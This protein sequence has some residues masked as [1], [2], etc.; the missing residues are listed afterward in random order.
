MRV[1]KANLGLASLFIIKLILLLRGESS[2]P[3][4]VFG[5]RRKLTYTR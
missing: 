2:F 4:D 5:M 1:L 3:S